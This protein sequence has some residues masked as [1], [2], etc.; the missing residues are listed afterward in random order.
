MAAQIPNT[1]NIRKTK[2]SAKAAE[3]AAEL[4]KSPVLAESP[5]EL[6]KAFAKPGNSFQR[7]MAGMKQVL[8]SNNYLSDA[9]SDTLTLDEKFSL[10]ISEMY[11]LKK[12]QEATER[13]YVA[14][15]E[16]FKTHEDAIQQNSQG[17]EDAFD[18]IEKKVT[19]ATENIVEIQAENHGFTVQLGELQEKSEK[20]GRD[21]TLLKGFSDKFEKQ[22]DIL[23]AK[24]IATTARSMEKNIV[25]S[26]IPEMKKEN[27]KLQVSN[28]LRDKLALSFEEDEI[29]T[30]YHQGSFIPGKTRLMVVKLSQSLKQKAI[31]SREKLKQI[32]HTTGEVFFINPQLPE[33]ILAEKKAI[34]YEVKRIK[35]FNESQKNKKDQLDFYVKNKQLYVENEPHV[36]QV[37]PPRPTELFVTTAEQQKMDDMLMGMSQPKTK[38]GSVFVGVAIPVLTLEEVSRAY[39][40]VRQMYPSYDHVSMAYRIQDYSGYQD[41]GEHT[42]GVRLHA[43]LCD[44]RKKHLALFVARNFGGTNLG[45][46]RFSYIEE[47]AAQAI[48]R[49]L[50]IAQ[51]VP[52][53]GPNASQATP[54]NAEPNQSSVNLEQPFPPTESPREEWPSA[55]SPLWNTAP[56]SDSNP[57]DNFDTPDESKEAEDLSYEGDSES[58]NDTTVISNQSHL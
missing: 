13:K 46:I 19:T 34:Q 20:V 23:K 37:F 12:A 3:S 38:R 5:T 16:R 42:A 2:T 36:Q 31:D 25:I 47:V 33:A 57:E 18:E 58:E 40:K 17:Q 26:G 35:S 44:A 51:Y 41:D 14:L 55:D 22:I 10:V 48:E 8:Q 28:L 6:D 54:G 30:A 1:A 53:P 15:E 52:A 39:R 32:Q 43:L 27:C 24:N 7:D 56:V 49:L 21:I 11:R 29:K 4:A 45:P 50:D 9:F